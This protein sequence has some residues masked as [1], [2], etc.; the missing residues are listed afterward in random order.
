[1][2]K[3]NY[4][5]FLVKINKNILAYQDDYNSAYNHDVWLEIATHPLLWQY[6]SFLLRILSALSNDKSA[7]LCGHKNN[8]NLKQEITSNLTYPSWG[9]LHLNP[10]NKIISTRRKC[11]MQ[12]FSNILR[13][14]FLRY[15]IPLNLEFQSLK[16]SYLM[17]IIY[18]LIH[19]IHN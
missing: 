17:Q 19:D 4:F 5:F 6:S 18:P 3:N 8:D 10:V 7:I 9:W 15:H 16:G 11:Y 14:Q 13:I 1:M 12:I 2:L